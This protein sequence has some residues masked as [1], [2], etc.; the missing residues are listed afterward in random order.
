MGRPLNV[1]K[2]GYRFYYKGHG[3]TINVYDAN[4]HEIDVISYM[5]EGKG[6]PE[7]EVYE[8]INRRART[9]NTYNAKK[10]FHGV[11]KA[12]TKFVIPKGVAERVDVTPL[13]KSNHG[14]PEWDLPSAWK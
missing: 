14:L 7:N 9:Y 6:I 12:P 3:H 5:G 4:G 8:L 11:V 2:N 10:G 13:K 1:T